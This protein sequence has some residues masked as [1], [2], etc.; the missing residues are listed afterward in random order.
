MSL[1]GCAKSATAT[2][3][4]ATLDHR[5]REGLRHEGFCHHS[6]GVERDTP[7]CEERQEPLQ[8][9]RSQR[10]TRQPGYAVSLSW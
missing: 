7:F 9:P 10:I 2:G 4:N 1:S 8:Q 5:L 3:P 6:A